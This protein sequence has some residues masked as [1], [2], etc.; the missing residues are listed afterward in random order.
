MIQKADEGGAFEF[1]PGVRGPGNENFDTI[2]AIMDGEAGLTR[3]LEADPGTLVLFRGERALHRVTR[4][5]GDR[6][7][8]IALFSYDRQPGMMFGEASQRRVFGRVE[9]EAPIP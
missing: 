7:R 6:P 3:L 2:R 8:I 4:V 5:T 1:A 9:G